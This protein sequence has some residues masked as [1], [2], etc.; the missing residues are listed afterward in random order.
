M[1]AAFGSRSRRGLHARRPSTP[2]AG[3]AGRADR[4]GKAHPVLV[5]RDQSAEGRQPPKEVREARDL[6]TRLQMAEPGGDQQQVEIA[7]ADHLVGDV[8]AVLLRV[9]SLG[10]HA[11]RESATS[12]RSSTTVG[13]LLWDRTPSQAGGHAA[14]HATRIAGHR[15]LN[16]TEVIEW[17]RSPALAITGTRRVRLPCRRSRVRVP[18]S[19]YK[20]P[21]NGHVCRLGRKRSKRRGAV[22][23]GSLPSRESLQHRS[24]WSKAEHTRAAHW[25]A[26]I[27]PCLFRSRTALRVDTARVGFRARD[28]GVSALAGL[29]PLRARRQARPRAEYAKR[30]RACGRRSRDAPRLSWWSRR[31]PGRSG[32]SCFL[33]PPSGRRDA[34]SA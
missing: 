10:N 26:S 29:I 23:C 3:V 17:E 33:P 2:P 22:G 11:L 9:P 6:P 34:H 15:P 20:S 13:P 12:R 8:D 1:T 7:L 21:G 18:S 24:P 5:E 16:P 27:G 31:G 32:G 28:R 14:Q 4:V 30:C 25:D 19:A